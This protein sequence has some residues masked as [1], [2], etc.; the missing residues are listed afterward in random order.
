MKAMEKCHHSV[1]T[2][3]IW[4]NCLGV[5]WFNKQ[6]L[7]SD[8]GCFVPGYTTSAGLYHMNLIWIIFNWACS[9]YYPKYYCAALWIFYKNKATGMHI[10]N[11]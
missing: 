9:D 1:W 6:E 3:C 10:V 4:Q 8:Q 2:M 5:L 7:N 11:N